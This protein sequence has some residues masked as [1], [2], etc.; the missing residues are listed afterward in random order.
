[1]RV[2]IVDD[3]FDSRRMLQKIISIRLLR[4]GRGRE[5]GR[6]GFSRA[7]RDGETYA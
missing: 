6:G 5:G 1:M 3:D 7:M 4:R 2:L